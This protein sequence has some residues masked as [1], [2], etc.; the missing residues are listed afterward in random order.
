MPFTLISSISFK[1]HDFLLLCSRL[2]AANNKYISSEASH[3]HLQRPFMRGDCTI[4]VI[5]QFNLMIMIMTMSMSMIIIHINP[6]L[7]RSMDCVLTW[8]HWKSTWTGCHDAII[9]ERA[10]RDP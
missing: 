7:Y 1:G 2:F 5:L 3:G 9:A 6:C 8:M 10:Q 4:T